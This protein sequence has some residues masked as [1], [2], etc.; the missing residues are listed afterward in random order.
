MLSPVGAAGRDKETVTVVDWLVLPLDP[1][2]F[3]V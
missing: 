1:V 2:Q 3:K